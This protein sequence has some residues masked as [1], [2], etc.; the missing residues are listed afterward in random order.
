LGTGPVLVDLAE[1]S[2]REELPSFVFVNKCDLV[3]DSEVPKEEAEAHQSEEGLPLFEAG[4]KTGEDVE[5]GMMR[6]L[7]S[8]LACQEKGVIVGSIALSHAKRESCCD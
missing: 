1:V 3:D 5:A 6:C 7:Q 4:A 2:P 8:L